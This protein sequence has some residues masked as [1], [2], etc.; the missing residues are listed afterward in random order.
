MTH[1]NLTFIFGDSL[2]LERATADNT[3]ATN[4]QHRTTNK[5]PSI[6]LESTINHL[7]GIVIERMVCG[8][9]VYKVLS[10]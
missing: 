5:A 7:Q 10:C 1:E 6:N 3:T 9:I 8:K 2:F 4:E